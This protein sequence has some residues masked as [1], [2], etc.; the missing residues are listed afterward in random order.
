MHFLLSEMPRKRRRGRQSKKKRELDALKKQIINLHYTDAGFQNEHDWQ[1]CFDIHLLLLQCPLIQNNPE[2]ID[3][4][5][6]KEIATYATGSCMDCDLCKVSFCILRENTVD[7]NGLYE[8]CKEN[9]YTFSNIGSF[10]QP[11]GKK[12]GAERANEI[13]NGDF[14]IG[15][16]GYKK[17][18]EV[19]ICSACF[20]MELVTNSL[21]CSG[22]RYPVIYQKWWDLTRGDEAFHKSCYHAH[23]IKQAYHGD[24]TY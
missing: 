7:H 12:K 8:I 1:E 16:I 23:Q 4:N 20:P 2:Q 21:F 14:K 9:D 13:F 3:Q 11:E 22:C 18:R 24:S 6:L 10:W 17:K 5:I 15:F 19:Y